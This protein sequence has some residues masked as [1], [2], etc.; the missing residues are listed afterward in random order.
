MATDGRRILVVEDNKA[1]RD[2]MA[3]L[4]RHGGHAV[5]TCSDGADAVEIAAREHPDLI[6]MDLQLDR[7]GGLEAASMLGADPALA[8]IPLVAVTAYAMAG[9]RERV[10]ASGFDDYLTKPIEPMT[11]NAQVDQLLISLGGARNKE[12]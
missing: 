4:L 1:S 6:L 9:D 12:D 8:A 5:L 10:L 3:Y 7:V 2:L 11:F